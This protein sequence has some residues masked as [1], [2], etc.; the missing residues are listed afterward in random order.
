MDQETIRKEH[1]SM[2]LTLSMTEA[3]LIRMCLKQD[4]LAQKELYNRYKNAMYTTAYRMTGDFE[5]ANDVLQEAFVKVFRGLS[6]FRQESTLGAWIKTIVVRTA[7][8]KIKTQTN[9][10]DLDQVD[11]TKW[12]DWGNSLDTEYLE[13]A[14]QDLPDGYRSV[15]VLI[16]IE[17]FSHQEVADFLNISIGTSKS[18]LFYAKKRLRASLTEYGFEH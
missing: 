17:G 8:S 5:S 4:R 9:F 2:S 18:Q 15:F 3:D 16:E 13:R 10:E 12:L 11:H 7:L 14:I 1:R 6:S